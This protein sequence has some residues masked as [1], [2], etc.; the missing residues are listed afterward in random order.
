MP[1]GQEWKC[2]VELSLQMLRPC[3]KGIVREGRV[4]DTKVDRDTFEVGAGHEKLS[5]CDGAD[6]N[7][8]F[9]VRVATLMLRRRMCFLMAASRTE[10]VPSASEETD[11][12]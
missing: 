4:A 1:E 10:V 9:C 7:H 2:R 11:L 8:L 5:K 6:L 3:Y 12:E